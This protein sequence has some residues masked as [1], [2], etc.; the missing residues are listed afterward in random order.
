MPDQSFI[1]F[2]EL[3]TPPLLGEAGRGLLSP[4]VQELVS[5]RP[6]WIIRKGNTVFFL[7]LILLLALT[8]VIQYPDMVKGSLRL[9][10]VNP[11]KLL[12][13][14]T[15][16]KLQKLIATNEQEVKKGDILAYLQ[17]TA[18]HAQVLQLRKWID[19]TEQAILINNLDVLMEHPFPPLN[20][21]GELQTGY[22]EFYKIQSETQQLLANGYYQ[23]KKKALQKDID[24]LR[25]ISANAQQQE[26]LLY[27]EYE[28]QKIEF[29][30]RESLAK[31]KVIAPLEFNQDKEKM[32]LKQQGL[33]Q[34]KA[35]II[36][37][38]IS[39]HNKQKEVLDLQK[40]FSDQEQQFR[41][42]LLTLKSSVEEWMQQYIVVAPEE[43]KLLFV[44]F[45]L[46]NQ[47]LAAG[48]ELFYIQPMQ[49]SYYGEMLVAQNGL[50]KV[51]TGQSIIIKIQSYPSNEFGYLRGMVEYIA[52]MPGKRDSFSIKVNL[53]QGLKTNYGKTIVFRNNLLAY[54][55]IITDNRRLVDRFWGQLKEVIER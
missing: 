21:L 9:V 18:S 17:S 48:Q 39:D 26:Q 23:Q 11:P 38:N 10:A 42:A 45:L 27:K 30:A 1:H 29:K 28:L 6:H 15:G 22:E 35:Q 14:K 33:E 55:E 36:N 2:S 20:N 31:D 4:D 5:Y 32:L 51:R 41:S 19:T 49:S 50:G 13:A 43:G 7:V 24:Y 53:P 8:W 52:N 3:P 12:I 47:L 46:E 25:S 44:S 54:A 40:Y 16:G 34:M 37:N